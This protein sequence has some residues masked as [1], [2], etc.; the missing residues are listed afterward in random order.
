MI[1]NNPDVP[2]FKKRGNK[3]MKRE[4]ILTKLRTPQGK[5]QI[6]KEI[7]KGEYKTNINVVQKYINT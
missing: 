6:I 3:P 7:T 5:D 2:L 1:A 4:E